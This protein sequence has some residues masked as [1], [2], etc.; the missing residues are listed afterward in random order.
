MSASRPFKMTISLD[1]LHHLG[2]GLYSNIPAV[3]S[4]LVANAWDA[5]ATEIDIVLDAETPSI[6]I[7]DNGHGMSQDD[8]KSTTNSLLSD[9]GAVSLVLRLPRVGTLWVARGSA[10][11]RR[12]RSPTPSRCIPRTESRRLA[13]A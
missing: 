4:E 3:L 12:F 9:T 6:E 5:D 8:I 10:S 11:W 2:I 13:F 1:V 7:S